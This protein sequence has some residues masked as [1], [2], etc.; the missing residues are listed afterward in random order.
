MAAE[1]GTD[2]GSVRGSPA[3]SVAP[4][5]A[6]ED[7]DPRRCLRAIL[8]WAGQ[9]YRRAWPRATG[10][11]T[12]SQ[13]ASAQTASSVAGDWSPAEWVECEAVSIMAGSCA[14]N[15]RIS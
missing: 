10:S 4:S 1:V 2:I 11:I 9:Q 8:R 12:V 3:M 5:G 15:R 14:R 13:P 7:A 6:A